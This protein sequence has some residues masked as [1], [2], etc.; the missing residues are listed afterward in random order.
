M[1]DMCKK[2]ATSDGAGICSHVK[3]LFKCLQHKLI[4]K[5]KRFFQTQKFLCLSFSLI[6]HTEAV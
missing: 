3:Y 5:V 1:V 6:L 4:P 2:N